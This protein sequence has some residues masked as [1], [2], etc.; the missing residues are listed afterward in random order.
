M[1]SVCVGC[2]KLRNCTTVLGSV[3]LKGISL[4]ND[5][6][7]AKQ[8]QFP[9]LKEITGHLIVTFL[10]DV[11]SLSDIL[12]NLAVIRG[13]IANLFK[14][15]AFVVYRNAGLRTLGLNALT[16]VKQ[17]GIKIEF[18]PFL[19]YLDRVRWKSLMNHEKYEL[20]IG[21]NSQDCFDKCSGCQTPSG[22]GSSGI[23]YCW[24]EEKKNCQTCK[25]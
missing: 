5:K 21:S 1:K 18:N 2:E 20:S 9:L 15:Y 6:E 25:S 14:D 3:H 22:H 23:S 4:K 10:E 13:R 11:R 17:G 19:C 12:P 16:T 7:L 24:A 8:I